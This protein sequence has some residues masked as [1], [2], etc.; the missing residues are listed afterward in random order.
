MPRYSIATLALM[1]VA[2]LAGCSGSNLV[3]VHGTVQ[4]DG[5]PIETGTVRMVAVDGKT[6]SAQ[7]TIKNGEYR[8]EVAPGKKKV[9]I[10]GFR[11][12]GQQRRNNDPTAPLEDVTEPIVPAKFNT[13]TELTCEVVAG[14]DTQDF[15]LKSN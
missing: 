10:Q 7:T 3:E 14:N 11:V 1:L 4:L 2:A 9:E 13:R 8:I 12:I 15:D 6:P 5:K